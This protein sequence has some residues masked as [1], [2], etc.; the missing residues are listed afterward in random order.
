MLLKND[1]PL[2]PLKPRSSLAVIGAFAQHPRYQGAGSSRVNPT[3]VECALDAIRDAA[4]GSAAIGYAPGYDPTHSEADE[5]LIDEAV[6]VAR[7]AESAVVFAGLPGVYES[8]GFD[9]A[10]MGLPAQHNRLIEAVCRANPDTT[11]VLANGAPVE[12]PWVHAPKA[13]LACHLAGQAGGGAVADLLFGRCNPSGKLAE[14]YPVQ[15]AD[16]ACDRWFPG[17]GRQVQ[18]REGLYVGYR[19]FDSAEV[20]PLFPFGHG[21]SYTDFDYRNLQLSTSR[22]RPGDSGRWRCFPAANRVSGRCMH[23]WRS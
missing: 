5:Q 22:A 19:F 12:M 2:L 23:W 4:G 18:Y 7:D 6:A 11:V 10:H 8:E 16:L 20:A 21:L 15:Q 17:E 14:T 9:R 13:I 3:R 1:G